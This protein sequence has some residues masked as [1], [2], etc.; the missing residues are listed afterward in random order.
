M[1]LLSPFTN[2]YNSIRIAPA[3]TDFE[4]VQNQSDHAAQSCSTVRHSELSAI[5][6]TTTVLSLRISPSTSRTASYFPAVSVVRKRNLKIQCK[7]SISVK[8]SRTRRL[9]SLLPES[10]AFELTGR[11]RK[12]CRY[13]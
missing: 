9:I 1:F 11:T 4:P 12:S 10:L 8:F 3:N 7:D 2:F 13:D 5:N 6:F